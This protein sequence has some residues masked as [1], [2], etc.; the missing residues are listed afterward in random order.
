MFD[1]FLAFLITFF[2]ASLFG[3]VVHRILHQ[4]WSRRLYQAHMTHHIKLYPPTDFSS[5]KYRDS[6]KDSTPKFFMLAGLP[7]I[8]IPIILYLFNWVSSPVFITI[9]TVEIL[10][11]FLNDYLHDAFHIKNFWLHKVPYIGLWF[12]SLTRLHYFHHVDMGSN[13][14]IFSFIWDRIFQTFRDN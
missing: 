3:Y 11:G 2:V 7:L 8:I 4:K 10:I 9:L 6:G 12:S 5:E 14:G 13:Y 1:I